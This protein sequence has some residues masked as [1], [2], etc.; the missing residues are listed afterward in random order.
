MTDEDILNLCRAMGELFPQSYTCESPE[1]LP[2]K[3]VVQAILAAYD[4]GYD[5]ALC[6]WED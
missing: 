4:R 2:H 6:N 5:D 1:W 3:W